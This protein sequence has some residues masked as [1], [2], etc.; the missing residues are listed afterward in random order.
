MHYQ[1]LTLDERITRI[2]NSLSTH[3]L[4]EQLSVLA[5]DYQFESF[6]LCLTLR[7]GLQQTELMILTKTPESWCTD[8]S[9]NTGI[10]DDPVFHKTQLQSCP[11]VWNKHSATQDEPLMEY[12]I[13]AGMEQ[14]AAFPLHGPNGFNGYFALCRKQGV[15]IPAQTVFQIMCLTQFILD[16]A[17]KLFSPQKTGFSSREKECLFWV[18]EGKTSWEIAQ[19]L[20]ITERTVNFHLN[21]AIRKSGC[22]NRYQTVAKSIITGELAHTMNRVNIRHM[23]QFAM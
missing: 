22:K 1:T 3:A 8:Y 7:R 5:T 2:Q 21:N 16:Q 20:G 18:S 10:Q 13:S 4:T 6:Q 17:I 15:P 23:A 11:F 14:G 19:I 12:W 9:Q